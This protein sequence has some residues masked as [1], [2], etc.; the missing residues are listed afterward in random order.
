[1]KVSMN[2]IY[3][4]AIIEYVEIKKREQVQEEALEMISEYET[5]QR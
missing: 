4:T 1:M 2:S 3:Q 5:I